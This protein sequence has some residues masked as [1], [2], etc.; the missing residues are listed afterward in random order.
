MYEINKINKIKMGNLEMKS[1]KIKRL[2]LLS[3]YLWFIGIV[4]YF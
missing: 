4:I 2:L 3:P 1:I